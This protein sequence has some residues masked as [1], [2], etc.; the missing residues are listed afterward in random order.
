MRSFLILYASLSLF[1]TQKQVCPTHLRN[2]KTI[3]ERSVASAENSGVITALFPATGAAPSIGVGSGNG[4]DGGS[5]S[6]NGRERSPVT[7]PS[8]TVQNRPNMPTL[9][10]SRVIGTVRNGVLYAT[11][12]DNMARNAINAATNTTN[13]RAIQFDITADAEYESISITFNRTAMQ[14]LNNVRSNVRNIGIGT[15]VIDL[16]LDSAAIG[17]VLDQTSGDVTVSAMRETSLS[18]SARE[19]IDSRPV[20]EVTITGTSSTDANAENT[21][22]IT[23][24]RD[25]TITMGLAYIP[26]VGERTGNL[27]GVYV[28]EEGNPHM[29]T[30]S[31]FT[32]GRVIFSRNS[33]SLY[34]VGYQSDPVFTDIA[35]HWARADI[36][37]AASRGLVSGTVTG[38]EAAFSPNTAITR[39]DFIMA[40]GRLSGA[41]VSIHT[42]SRFIDVQNDNPAMP[43]IE[44]AVLNGI[45]SGIGSRRFAPNDVINREEMAVTM[46]NY[47]ES[48]NYIMPTSRQ[49]VVF[50]DNARITAG[51]R[52]DVRSI[53]QTGI[54][55][56]R[57][58]NR[59]DP[60]EA[61]TRAEAAV[62][63]RRFVELVIDES[64]ARGWARNDS[65]S[66]QFI[67][68]TGRAVTGWHTDIDG[69]RFWFDNRGIMISDR[70]V[71]I[72]G[73]WYYFYDSGRLAV[74]TV[75]DGYT[76]G[77]DGA[78]E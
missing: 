10:R 1:L 13:G 32:D 45:V 4:G 39:A 75:I 24:L 72:A 8:V 27:F 77:E 56:G 59:F 17:T 35:G 20:F 70:W 63:L 36:D 73:N 7:A 31:S 14:R 68:A 65:G 3:Y 29:L 57:D 26:R 2:N 74:S 46:V 22:N 5:S 21:S 55:V 64:T 60:R 16:T 61:V 69:E 18:E 54:I 51:A 25:G 66:W 78:R 28:D 40:L 23:D 76:I 67:D 62:I 9:A 58:N 42:A 43:Y 47:A 49:A 34:G 71:Q 6:D 33:L 37:F 52:A 48:I 30:N 44:W 11:I 15:L 38:T 19:I 41:D 12:T 53:Q 50:A